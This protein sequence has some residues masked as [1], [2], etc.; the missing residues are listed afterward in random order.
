MRLLKDGRHAEAQAP[1]GEW[2]EIRQEALAEGHWLIF[3]SMTVLGESLAGQ[4]ADHSLTRLSE[5]LARFWLRR[6]RASAPS[7]MM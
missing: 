6:S 3:N 5:Y 4:G 2:L 1:L 7:Q